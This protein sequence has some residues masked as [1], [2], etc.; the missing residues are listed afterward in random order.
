MKEAQELKGEHESPC[1]TLLFVFPVPV[2]PHKD[3]ANQ[4]MKNEGSIER[5]NFHM[6][7][8]R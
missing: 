1:Y 5:R 4:D 8:Q 2:K 6:G 3:S 7:K